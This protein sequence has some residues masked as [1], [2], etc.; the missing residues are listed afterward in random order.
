MA[1]GWQQ[2]NFC[3]NN[4]AESGGPQKNGSI[5]VNADPGLLNIH[6]NI[7]AIDLV[8]LISFNV[9]LWIADNS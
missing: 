3:G 1:Q 8:G 4:H 7:Y 6:L 9:M 5:R 2:S